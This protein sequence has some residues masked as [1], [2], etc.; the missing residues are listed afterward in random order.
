MFSG[1]VEEV[2][3]VESLKP[4]PGGARLV[5]R[6]SLGELKLGDSVAVN[7]VCLT[8]VEWKG[9]MLSFDLSQETLSRSNLRFLKKGDPVNLERS[10]RVGDRIGGHFLQGHVDFTSPIEALSQRGEHWELRVRVP[11]EYLPYVVEKGSIGIDGISLTINYIQG[12]SI[13]INIIP[14]T[15]QNT[16]LR[17]REKGDLVNVELDILGKYVVNYLNLLQKDARIEKLWSGLW[18]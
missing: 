5:V 12:E 10:L 2:G 14:H 7:G 8:L 18:G 6:S 4:T 11:R 1:I 17:A 15:Y 16:N 13:S 3:V 9:Q